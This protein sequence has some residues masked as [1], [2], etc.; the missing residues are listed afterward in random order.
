MHDELCTLPQCIL[1][2]RRE[3]GAGAE[4]ASSTACRGQRLAGNR[5]RGSL[6]KLLGDGCT[7][8]HGTVLIEVAWRLHRI[9]YFGL[10][11][12]RRD[13]NE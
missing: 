6:E 13:S 3:S 10:T 12:S 7:A 1:A 2:L 11:Q 4:L 5:G 8:R 9:G